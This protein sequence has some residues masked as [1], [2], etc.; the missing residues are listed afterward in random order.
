SIRHTCK[1]MPDKSKAIHPSVVFIHL[2][3]ASNPS[4][5]SLLPA[6]PN[7]MMPDLMTPCITLRTCSMDSSQ[8][9]RFNSSRPFLHNLSQSAM[10]NKP[11][12][13]PVA[14]CVFVVV[15]ALTLKTLGIGIFDMSRAFK[16]WHM[17]TNKLT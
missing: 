4:N 15:G 17:C 1:S 12:I 6:R 3:T 13:S 16:E 7:L 8:L 14:D 11:A 2:V 5:P 9:F 10:E